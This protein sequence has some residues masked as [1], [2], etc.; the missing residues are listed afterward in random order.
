MGSKL[1]EFILRFQW[2]NRV[3]KG[4]DQRS[5]LQNMPIKS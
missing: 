3:E 1:I 4:E 2:E 5:K